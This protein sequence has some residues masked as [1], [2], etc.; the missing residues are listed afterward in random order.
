MLQDGNQNVSISSSERGPLNIRGM[1]LV[2]LRIPCSLA[3]A[4]HR[5]SAPPRWINE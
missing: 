2:P 3:N 4:W 1:S 5:K